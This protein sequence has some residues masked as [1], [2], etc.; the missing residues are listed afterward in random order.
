MVGVKEI[1]MAEKTAAVLTKSEVICVLALD[2]N[3]AQAIEFLDEANFN[4]PNCAVQSNSA[5]IQSMNSNIAVPPVA[6]S[7]CTVG[8]SQ[9]EYFPYVKHACSPVVDPFADLVIPD[10]A[11]SCD[12]R[13]NVYVQGTNTSAGNIGVLES[14]LAATNEGES[15]IPDGSILYPG[16]YC[17]GLRV[18]GANVFLQPGV[19][20]VWG[21][22]EF[23]QFAT[24]IGNE[25]TF[26]LKGESNRLLIEEGAQLSLKAPSRGLTAGL[27]FWQKYLKFWPY[28]RGYVPPSPDRVIA[29]SEISS[30][31][32]LK[33]VGTAYLPDHELIITSENAVASQSPATS[34]IAR[35]MKFAGKANMQVNVDHVA[36]DI[37]PMLP[38]S[39]DGARLVQ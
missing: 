4:S 36:G 31:G 21:D 33:I 39:D 11:D 28:V 7:F 5:S 9:G 15:I 35:R 18:E 24:V 6:K 22:L 20:H 10:A 25:V 3:G 27:V 26:I 14:Q 19:Y 29:T 23:S 13:K 32:G 38:R 17:R 30:G 1:E 2:P 12:Q 34:F 16:I 8:E 37:P